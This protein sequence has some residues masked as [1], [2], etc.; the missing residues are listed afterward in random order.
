MPLAIASIVEGDLP[1][2]ARKLGVRLS[3]YQ[4]FSRFAVELVIVVLLAGILGN[5]VADAFANGSY[6]VLA[7]AAA[8]LA[9]LSLSA[10][11]LWKAL[12]PSARTSAIS[13]Y[14]IP[15]LA[16]PSEAKKRIIEPL[17]EVIALRD[18]T[19]AP[20]STRKAVRRGKTF[21]IVTSRYEQNDGTDNDA[22]LSYEVHAVYRATS[23]VPNTSSADGIEIGPKADVY[24]T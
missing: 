14:M 15:P 6:G 2:A 3:Q 17:A 24:L 23:K 5:V 1:G 7:T 18:I 8:A 22:D 13:L 16:D 11:I 12:L 20:V 4:Q 10:H 9:I 19:D 21:W